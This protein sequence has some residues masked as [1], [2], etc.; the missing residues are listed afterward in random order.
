MLDK[1]YTSHNSF[2][3]ETVKQ[4]RKRFGYTSDGYSYYLYGET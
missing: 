2:N 4:R 3:G 1:D